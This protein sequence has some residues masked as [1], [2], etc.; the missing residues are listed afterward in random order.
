MHL[1]QPTKATIQKTN[2]KSNAKTRQ[3]TNATRQDNKT[4]KKTNDET[5]HQKRQ[6]TKA[7]RK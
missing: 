6:V 2:D 7:T 3:L 4:I 5:R 1:R